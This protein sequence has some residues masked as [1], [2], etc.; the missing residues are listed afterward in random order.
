M[1]RLLFQLIRID[2][3]IFSA[4]LGMETGACAYTEKAACDADIQFLLTPR[5]L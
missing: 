5:I 4:M 2:I 3:P 1:F